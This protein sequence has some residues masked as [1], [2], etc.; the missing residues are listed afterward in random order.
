MIVRGNKGEQRDKRGGA[1]GFRKE[2]SVTIF[3]ISNRHEIDRRQ[4]CA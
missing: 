1:I 4:Q 3:E 2:I